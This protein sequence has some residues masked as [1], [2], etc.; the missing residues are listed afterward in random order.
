MEE[1]LNKE[2]GTGPGKSFFAA[3]AAGLAVVVAIVVAVVRGCGGKAPTP[4]AP[5]PETP[6]TPAERTQRK[7]EERAADTN[8]VAK[9]NLFAQQQTNLARIRGEAMREFE[10]WCAGFTATNEAARAAFEEL[11]RLAADGAAQTNGAYA[12]QV[13][14]V[15]ALVKAD[16][17]GRRLLAK[18]ERIDRAIE[19]NRRM[20]ADLLGDRLRKQAEAGAAAEVA[21]AER[22]RA[23]R[24]AKGELKVPPPR[25]PPTNRVARLPAPLPPTNGARRVAVPPPG[26]RGPLPPRRAVNGPNGRGGPALPAPHPAP[27][28]PAVPQPGGEAAANP[29]AAKPAAPQPAQPGGPAPVPA[30]AAPVET[31]D[32][33]S[34]VP[35]APPAQNTP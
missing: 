25:T 16:P 12:A 14:K 1:K 28:A 22:F 32:V 3:L 33:P 17:M 23:A 4:E 30:A 34:A 21:D 6:L 35:P 7:V 26:A 2:K 27:I 20:F 10:T 15:D 5:A 8:Y 13:E 11:D 29:A 31:A 9:M 19:D 24:I 18:R